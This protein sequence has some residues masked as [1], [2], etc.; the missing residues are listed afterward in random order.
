ML[1]T[2]TLL[3]AIIAALI[4]GTDRRIVRSLKE[5]H[6]LSPDAAVPLP[7]HGSIWRWR[8]HR[9]M[10]RGVL[11]LAPTDRVYLDEAAWQAYRSSR[12]RRALIVLAILL[13]VAVFLMWMSGRPVQ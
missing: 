8:V 11:L 13:P 5:Q 12:R 2:T 6:A 1:Q 9:L 4:V 10:G 7:E 3:P